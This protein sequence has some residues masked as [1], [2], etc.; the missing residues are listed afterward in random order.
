MS[1]I[2]LSSANRLRMAKRSHLLVLAGVSQLLFNQISAGE[3][4]CNSAPRTDLVS[5]EAYT[6]DWPDFQ[7]TLY[8]YMSG[9]MCGETCQGNN[10]CSFNVGFGDTKLRLS[11]EYPAGGDSHCN[12]QNWESIFDEC[13]FGDIPRTG[14]S[15]VEGDTKLEMTFEKIPEEKPF[16]DT[17]KIADTEVSE[18]ISFWVMDFVYQPPGT[19]GGDLPPEYGVAVTGVKHDDCDEIGNNRSKYSA[20]VVDWIGDRSSTVT[21]FREVSSTNVD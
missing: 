12:Q 13:W 21:K 6:G 4:N 5:Y 20:N 1:A 9:Q 16:F 2:T 8:P 3:V 11:L 15:W 19:R 14:G 18:A 10:N 7:G 17:I